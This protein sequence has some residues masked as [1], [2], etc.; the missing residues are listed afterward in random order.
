MLLLIYFYFII[1]LGIL[2][3]ELLNLHFTRE[4]KDVIALK[5]T[6]IDLGCSGT[7]GR[8]AANITWIKDGE[9]VQNSKRFRVTTHGSLS[10]KK[11]SSKRHVGQYQC[12]A[13]NPHGRIISKPASLSIACK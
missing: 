6:D 1:F 2:G 5:G 11:V 7:S 3:N 10:L 8:V 12:V 4:P 9:Q 13:S